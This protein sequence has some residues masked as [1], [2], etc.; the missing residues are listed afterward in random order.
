MPVF[1]ALIFGVIE[2]SGVIMTKSGTSNASQASAR[3]ASVQGNNAL[4]D[5]EIL[6][7]LRSEAAGLP[8]GEIQQIVIWHASGPGDTVPVACAVQGSAGV[9][10]TGN[11]NAVGNC[12]VYNKPEAPGGAFQ[13]ARGPLYKRYFGCPTAPDDGFN[14][15]RLDCKWPAQTRKVTQGLPGT[16]AGNA[17]VVPD[18]VGVYIRAK[19]N[20][21]TGLFGK[22]VTVE[23]TGI[24]RIEP[25]K[26]VTT[27]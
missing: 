4:A 3:M 17:N 9:T 19:H 26:Y 13:L 15:Q 6:L 11:P 24:G 27:L 12:N 8:R 1:I 22:S 14:Y 7:R 16:T 20:Y 18:Y 2:F 10:V 23:E 25:Q 21:Y 5:R